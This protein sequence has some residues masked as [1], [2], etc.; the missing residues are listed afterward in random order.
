MIEAATAA[1]RYLLHGLFN[2]RADG[3]RIHVGNQ[4]SGT[5][6]REPVVGNQSSGT[7]GLNI[8]GGFNPRKTD[9]YIHVGNRRFI[10]KG[11]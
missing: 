3:H 11:L 6:R 7:D 2:P 5:S 10:M 1:A 9:R 8:G 4:S